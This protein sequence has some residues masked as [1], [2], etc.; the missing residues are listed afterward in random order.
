[1]PPLT[2]KKQSSRTTAR[3]HLLDTRRSNV[4]A[5]H[6]EYQER[7]IATVGHA[8]GTESAFAQH[9]LMHPSMWSQIKS[10][11]TI[12][13]LLA[14]RIEARCGRPIGWLDRNHGAVTV[15]AEDSFV[16]LA[17]KIWRA[18]TARGKRELRTMLIEHDRKLQL[19]VK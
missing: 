10:S 15:T 2:S 9:L 17:R 11:R 8:R 13:D 19:K 5:L 4:L 12:T 6:Q 1:M 14:R 18:Q 3:Q 7:A 16:E